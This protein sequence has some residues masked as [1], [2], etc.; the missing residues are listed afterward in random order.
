VGGGIAPRLLPRI[1]DGTFLRGFTDKGRFR[2]LM[3]TIPVRL[4]ENPET[5][6]LGAARFAARELRRRR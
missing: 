2:G 6:V 5:A 3:E 1:A 4:I